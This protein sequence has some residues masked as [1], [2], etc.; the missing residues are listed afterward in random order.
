[1]MFLRAERFDTDK[2]ADRLLAF[3]EQKLETSGKELLV[4]DITL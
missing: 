3:F 1:M 2:A 4:K